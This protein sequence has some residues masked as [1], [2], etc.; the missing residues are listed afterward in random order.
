ME[1]YFAFILSFLSLAGVVVFTTY[2][3]HNPSVFFTIFLLGFGIEFIV[4]SFCVKILFSHEPERNHLNLFKGWYLAHIIIPACLV[5][6][7]DDK[8]IS[9]AGTI[10]ITVISI[11]CGLMLLFL[12][13]KKS[14]S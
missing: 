2:P 14:K 11:P 8:M 13:F 9:L 5:F 4:F 10:I 6:M 1:K 3:E 7:A 12:K